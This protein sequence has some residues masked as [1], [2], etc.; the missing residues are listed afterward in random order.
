[1]DEECKPKVYKS[2]GDHAPDI[3]IDDKADVSRIAEDIAAGEHESITKSSGAKSAGAKT[4]GLLGT[5]S[6]GGASSLTAPSNLM[7]G[8]DSAERS[9]IIRQY[10]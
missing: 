9:E 5:A 1:M 4:N 3:V 2:E 10:S 7:N 8:F 6:T